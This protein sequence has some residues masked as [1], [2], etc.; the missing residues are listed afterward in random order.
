MVQKKGFWGRPGG[1]GPSDRDD[2]VLAHAEFVLLGQRGQIAGHGENRQHGACDFILIGIADAANAENICELPWVGVV[3]RRRPRRQ[4]EMTA[5][6]NG[7]R[8]YF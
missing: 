1:S 6:D 8:Y 4:R 3:L 7:K 5:D 2:L